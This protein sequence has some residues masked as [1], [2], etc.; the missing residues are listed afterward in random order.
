MVSVTVCSGSKKIHAIFNRYF[1]TGSSNLIEVT[2]M[3][4]KETVYLSIYIYCTKYLQQTLEQI[5]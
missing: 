3:I 1:E 4:P 5:I 2:Q